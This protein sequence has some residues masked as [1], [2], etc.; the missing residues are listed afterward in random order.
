[1][2]QNNMGHRIDPNPTIA[3]HHEQTHEENVIAMRK[4]IDLVSA[5][6]NSTKPLTLPT[7]EMSPG[8]WATL[9]T[10]EDEELARRVM[11][12]TSQITADD[13]GAAMKDSVITTLVP[14]LSIASPIVGMKFDQ[15][16]LD[17]SLLPLEPIEVVLK[18]LMFGAKK[19][20]PGNWKH[21]DDHERRYYNAAM[22]HLASW[23]KGEQCDPETGIN[24]LGHAICCLIFLLG[25]ADEQK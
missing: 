6:I 16:K 22:R 7:E 4:T 14:Q 18:V 19:Y 2:K 9:C 20:A 24:H 3:D 25:R 12:D 10:M 23:Q 17:W 8:E 15:N 21:V 13:W 11:E 5:V 1:M